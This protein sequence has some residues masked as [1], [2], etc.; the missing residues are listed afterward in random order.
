[1]LSPQRTTYNGTQPKVLDLSRK[2]NTSE[3]RGLGSSLVNCICFA[4]RRSFPRSA[5]HPCLTFTCRTK[6]RDNWDGLSLRW[7]GK[8]QRRYR[9]GKGLPS[10][11]KTWARRR[12]D[13]RS[14]LRGSD[15]R[16]WWWDRIDRAWRERRL[17]DNC[18]LE[19][20]SFARWCDPRAEYRWCNRSGC[21]NSWGRPSRTRTRFY[22]PQ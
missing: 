19:G 15:R 10:L 2:G 5:G 9:V 18:R 7:R 13:R 11:I 17:R 16:Q 21:G 4:A 20:C 14:C 8:E 12:Q 6:L 1:M 22:T 3:G